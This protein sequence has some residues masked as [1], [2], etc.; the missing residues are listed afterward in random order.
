MLRNIAPIF[1][2]GLSVLWLVSASAATRPWYGYPD[3]EPVPFVH[4]G[5][6]VVGDGMT[7]GIA[8]NKTDKMYRICVEASKE[9]VPLNVMYDGQKSTVSPGDCADFEAMKIRVSAA[10]SLGPDEVLI[11]RYHHI[12]N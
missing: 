11:G 1:V 9:S 8:N 3:D 12:Q 2:G 5:E 6:F 7:K 4:A 10:G